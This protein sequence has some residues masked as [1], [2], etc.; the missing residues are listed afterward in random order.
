MR[1]D[2]E[3][4]RPERTDASHGLRAMALRA[5]L[6]ATAPALIAAQAA[7]A[8]PHGDGAATGFTASAV[9]MA[10]TTADA[11]AGSA[12]REARGLSK[13]FRSAAR[14]LAPSVVT[15]NTVA[16]G[17]A[18]APIGAIA[19]DML[20]PGMRLPGMGAPR[21]PS[22]AMRG[23][24]TGAV[25]SRDGH[26][27][28]ANH[29]VEGADEIEIV[30][31]D[32]RTAKATVV[33]LDPG[34][35][36]AVLRTDAANLAKDLEPAKFG[37][38][39]SLD[40]GDWVVAIGAPFGLE[41]TVTAGIVSAKGRSDVGL[42]TFE[43]YIQT[44][45]AIN[46]G[47]S[48]GPLAN[49]D[50]EI[51]G[52]NSSIS[53]K[54]GGND[55]IGFAVPSAVA[56]RV[57]DAIVADGRVARG[58]LG[59]GVQ[60]VDAELASSLGSA[61]A[62]GVLVNSVVD[63]SPAARAGLEPGDVILD[64]D[65]ESV[66]TP[67]G[68]IATIGSNAPGKTVEIR[69]VRGGEQ[70]VAQARLAERASNERGARPPE[71]AAPSSRLAG[72]GLAIEELSARDAAN[73][74]IEAEEGAL[75]VGRVEEGSPAANAGL[76]PGDVIRRIGA[77]AVRTLDEVPAAL[78]ALGEGA[79]VPVLVERDGRARFVLVRAQRDESD[80]RRR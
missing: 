51:V 4:N 35:D 65:G 62:T 64:I 49:L 38:S 74:G 6:A 48:G 50:G 47:N 45:A 66:R 29:V 32:G 54:S 23:T 61:T 72:L 21:G 28:T 14:R 12:Q 9:A 75:V 5:A 41:Q 46:P 40:I 59:I 16:R 43:N 19:P 68:L 42:A 18:R 24:G 53:S 56:R 77:R 58:W 80:T 1:H 34:T 17:E 10:G 63:G 37:E 33:G 3:R 22:P 60:P 20:P 30:F 52:I 78:D 73:L 31:H 70:R 67:G 11:Q 79:S 27:V 57:V 2:T 44:D 25:I 71:P 36:L 26:I 13:A 15:I 39:D 69:T 55:G 8:S 7:L 76:A